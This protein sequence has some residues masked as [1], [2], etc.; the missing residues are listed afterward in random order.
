MKAIPIA[1][2]A[3]AAASRSS[4]CC[5]PV[6]AR[7]LLPAVGLATVPAAVAGVLVVV[8]DVVVDVVVEAAAC[9]ANFMA[10]EV[11]DAKPR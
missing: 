5:T 6:L 8:V 3:L 4:S 1:S 2:S 10:L 11:E 7:L 9:T